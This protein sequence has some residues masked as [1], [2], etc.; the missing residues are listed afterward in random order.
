MKKFFKTPLV[1]GP[2]LTSPRDPVPH[3]R[4]PVASSLHGSSSCWFLFGNPARPGPETS[5]V[6]PVG[7]PHQLPGRL[8]Q[9]GLPTAARHKYPPFWKEGLLPNKGLR[10]SSSSS[11]GDAWRSSPV[12]GTGGCSAIQLGALFLTTESLTFWAWVAAAAPASPAQGGDN[13]HRCQAALGHLPYSM[14]AVQLLSPMGQG[15]L[16]QGEDSLPPS[17]SSAAQLRP[18]TSAEGGASLP[19]QAPILTFPA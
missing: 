3:P 18:T 8:H 6:L 2:F 5:Q 17:G 15:P 19:F 1:S 10:R 13:W 4:Q 16:R 9:G 14:E 7:K 11:S 12:C